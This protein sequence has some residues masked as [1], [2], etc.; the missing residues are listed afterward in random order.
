MGS[1]AGDEEIVI[2]VEVTPLKLAAVAAVMV[3]AACAAANYQ[4]VLQILVGRPVE[5]R[6][7]KY[8]YT[9]GEELRVTVCYRGEASRMLSDRFQI[10]MLNEEGEVVVSV[11]LD[12]GGRKCATVV[13]QLPE[14]IGPGTY[15][16]VVSLPGSRLPLEQARIYVARH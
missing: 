1:G 6:L 16:V 4:G 10:K 9:L 8:V 15:K 13:S 5:I 7:E 2:E 3:L 14:N 12:M 11:L